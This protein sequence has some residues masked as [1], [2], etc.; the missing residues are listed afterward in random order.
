MTEASGTAD[1]ARRDRSSLE[2]TSMICRRRYLL[3]SLYAILLSL[4]TGAVSLADDRATDKIRIYVATYS[5]VDGEGIFHADFDADTGSIGTFLPTGGITSPASIVPHPSGKYLYAT[6]LIDDGQ[7][8]P[9]GAVVAFTVDPSSGD[10]TEI[11]RR[12]AGGTGPCYLACDPHGKLLVVANCGTATVGCFSLTDDGRFGE[13]ATV[14]QHKGE[15]R[16]A[17]GKPQAHSINVSPSGRF[18]VAADL[19]LDRLF[20]YRLDEES[21]KMTPHEIPS[22]DVPQGAGPRHLTFH[23]S[24]RFA[25]VIGELGNIVTACAF[26]DE[27]GRL[28]PLQNI[29]SLPA[30]FQGESYAADIQIDPH[31]LFLYGTNRGDDSLAMWRVDPKSGRLS[32]I[33]FISSGGKFPRSAAIDPAGRFLIAANQKSD[34]LAVFRIDPQSGELTSAGEPTTVPQPVCVKFLRTP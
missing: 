23:P 30:D 9:T 4:A 11:D 16:N 15:S 24:G 12:T 19:G 32:S 3:L 28:R 6:S 13:S 1:I 17:E 2:N 8:Q 18:A 26:D 21:G 7:G 22:I 29:S 10:L 34:N 31:G 25:Y 5:A 27:S 33:G 14:I 20:V